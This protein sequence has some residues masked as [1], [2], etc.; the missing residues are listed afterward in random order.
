M[1]YK[2]ENPEF[3]EFI[4]N[5]E[6]ELLMVQRAKL[7]TE[8]SFLESEI[9]K[10]AN[11]SVTPF[12]DRVAEHFP[13]GRVGYMGGKGAKTMAREFDKNI[14][15]AKQLEILEFD[16]RTARN[17]YKV[18]EKSDKKLFNPNW[19]S[20]ESITMIIDMLHAYDDV[21][22]TKI[23]KGKTLTETELGYVKEDRKSWVKKYNT[24]TKKYT[25]DYEEFKRIPKD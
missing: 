4:K 12:G 21:I 7:K 25:L 20:T 8:I 6:A 10:T 2:T 24:R 19:Q 18:I 15:K 11:K 13:K 14:E 23:L 1:S 22:K 5:I 3:I 9:E 17:R 16:L